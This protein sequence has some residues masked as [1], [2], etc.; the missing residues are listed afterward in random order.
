MNKYISCV[1]W[2]RALIWSYGIF[3]P[4]LIMFINYLG[5]W[6]LIYLTVGF[7]N[8]I[9][10]D[11]LYWIW[12]LNIPWDFPQKKFWKTFDSQFWWISND[13][14]PEFYVFYC[15]VTKYHKWGG[16]SQ[17]KWITSEMFCRSYVWTWCGWILCSASHGLKSR[18][19]LGLAQGSLP[20]S[21]VVGR[22]PFLQL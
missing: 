16:L 20:S 17:H 15:C 10:I 9:R 12:N 6:Y 3:V 4:F 11:D 13:K 1:L 5:K 18:C 22:F 7:L 21:L 2:K 14:F 8:W 19:W